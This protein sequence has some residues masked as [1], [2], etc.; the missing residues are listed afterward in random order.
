MPVRLIATDSE[1]EL[2][3]TVIFKL[4]IKGINNIVNMQVDLAEIMF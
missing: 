3:L 4:D 1:K 2:H